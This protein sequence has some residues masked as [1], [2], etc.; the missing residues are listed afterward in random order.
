MQQARNGEVD[1]H[2]SRPSTRDRTRIGQNAAVNNAKDAL[3]HR[4]ETTIAASP[5]CGASSGP[6]TR[7]MA[8]SWTRP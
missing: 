8:A 3:Q 5:H 7:T 1:R 4:P 6:P 2:P